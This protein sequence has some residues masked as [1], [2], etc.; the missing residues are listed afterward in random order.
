MRSRITPEPAKSH[1][2][3]NAGFKGARLGWLSEMGE[4][5][6]A[7]VGRMVQMKPIASLGPIASLNVTDFRVRRLARALTASQKRKYLCAIGSSLA[8]SQIKSS[9]SARTS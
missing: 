3:V 7:S 9:P 8:G 6:H 2:E 1:V 5:V 4:D